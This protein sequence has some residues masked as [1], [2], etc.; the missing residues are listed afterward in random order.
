MKRLLGTLLLAL[1]LFTL[2]ACTKD[3]PTNNTLSVADLTDRE[4]A[5]FSMVSDQYVVFDFNQD[6]AY[7]EVSVG[8]E[9]YESGEL[10]SEQIG[11]IRTEIEEKGSIMFAISKSDDKEE[12]QII[13]IGISD[14]SGSMSGSEVNSSEMNHM[15]SV[16]GFTEEEI[17]PQEGK[18]VLASLCYSSDENGMSALSSDFYGD[19]EGH[20]DELDGYDVVYLLNAEFSK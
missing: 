14:N 15:S 17:I 6:G 5:L 16:W 7:K 19:A 10:V 13:H 1:P 8:I 2:I 20:M 9:K 3:T 4:K 11:S 12:Q 18:M